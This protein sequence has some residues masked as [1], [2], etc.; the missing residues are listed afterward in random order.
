MKKSCFVLIVFFFFLFTFYSFGQEQYGNIRGTIVDT[1]GT[2]LPGVAVTL[3]G[4]YAPKMLITSS[5]GI[6]RFVNMLPGT[7]TLKCE[8]SGFNTYIQENIVIRIGTNVDLEVKMLLS[9]LKEEVTVVAI[10]PVID[11]KKTSISSQVGEM[12]LEKLPSARDPWALMQQQPGTLAG[13][14]NVGGSASGSQYGSRARGALGGSSMYNMDGL[15]ITEGGDS[16]GASKIYYDFDTFEEVEV[17]TAGQDTSIQTAGVNINF[18]TRSGSNK[19]AGTTRLFYTGDK[20]QSDNR[21]EEIKNLRQAGDAINQ[22]M[23]YGF[24]LGGPIK[25]DKLWFQIG[26]GVQDIR[27]QTITGDPDETSIKTFNGK[28]NW[29]MSPKTRAMLG[30]IYN[31][32]EKWGRSASATRPP[33][34]T[35]HQHGPFPYWKAEIE[36]TF[37]D[38]LLVS[39]MGSWFPGGY[40]LDPKGGLDTQIGYDE[41]TGMWSG[42]Y[43]AWNG[44]YHAYDGRLAGILFVED[45]FGGNNE[46]KFGAYY[47]YQP[48]LSHYQYAGDVQRTFRDGV[49]YS[50]LVYREAPMR[51]AG[52]KISFYI[53]DAYT[54]GRLSLNLGLRFDREKTWTND[55]EIKASKIVPSLLPGYTSPGIDSNLIWNTLSPRLSMTYNISGDGKFVFRAGVARYGNPMPNDLATQLSTTVVCSAQYY[56]NDMN[57]DK[58]VTQ[59]ELV[60]FPYTGLI[61]F[62]GFDPFN[63]TVATSP[64]K[65]DPDLKS[66]RTDEVILGIEREILPDFS[67]RANVIFRRNSRLTWK[68]Y[69]GESRDSYIGPIMKTL[70]YGGKT[71]SYEYWTLAKY[72]P[73]GTYLTNRPDYHE[74]YSAFEVVADKRFSKKWMMNFSFTYQLNTQHYGDKGFNDPTNIAYLEG[75]SLYNVKWMAKINWIY[76]L[77]WGIDFSGFVNARQGYIFAPVLSVKTPERAAVG[78]SGSYSLYTEKYGS[79]NLET[80]YNCDLHLGKGFKLKEYGTLTL[81]VDVFNVFNFNFDLSR[82]ATINASNYNQIQQ[83]LNPRVIRFGMRYSY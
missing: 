13:A 16:T 64:N 43:W 17:T 66:P 31:A 61:S 82:R 74:N 75:A 67:M 30:F 73:T 72:R 42:S 55:S 32:K 36:H 10:V 47:R 70:T 38:N 58:K 34:T 9:T 33:E 56:W 59:N 26:Y 46:F 4:P 68:P 69:I 5:G 71:Y 6:F 45:I 29:Q 19:L 1:E 2:P 39:L 25:K 83:I 3:G 21:T 23:D 49:P 14:E 54:R 52:N 78:L 24:Q 15:N 20:F 57:G 37:S 44:K 79:Q 12:A 8:L 50:A 18:V 41:I 22:I 60:G 63:P 62:S 40:S 80:F 81:M 65:I 35:H 51:Y 77:P 11:L 53:T 7:Y 48:I 27:M 28:L 76:Q